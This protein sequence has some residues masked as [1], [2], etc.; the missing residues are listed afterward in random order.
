MVKLNLSKEFKTFFHGSVSSFLIIG[1]TGVANL[2]IRLLLQRNLSETDYGFFYSALAL[3]LFVLGF[4]DLGL[5]QALT[6]LTAKSNELNDKKMIKEQLKNVLQLKIITAVFFIIILLIF[7]PVIINYYLKFPTRYWLFLILIPVVLF[8]SINSCFVGFLNGLKRY[9]TALI[10]VLITALCWLSFIFTAVILKKNLLEVNS[11]GYLISTFIPVFIIYLLIKYKFKINLHIFKKSGKYRKI[12]NFC[13]YLAISTALLTSMYYLDTIML[14]S[15]K[16]LN[17]SSKYNIA[18]P[19]IHILQSFMVFVNV[20]TPIASEMWVKKDHK[21]LKQFANIALVLTILA[22][23]IV[24]IFFY[25]FGPEIVK[26][27]FKTSEYKSLGMT[28]TILSCGMLFFTLNNFFFQM[29]NSG[30]YEKKPVI[31]TVIGILINIVLNF[32]LIKNYD[33][34]GAAI[35]T[36][37]T[38]FIMSIVSYITLNRSIITNEKNINE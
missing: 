13:G 22:L 9:F 29:L 32:I 27:L 7:S 1:L 25:Y 34:N 14:T 2:A 37:M 38:Y 16:G 21:Q 23:P 6:I 36:A 28:V 5:G 24:F 31:I 33:Y 8:Q 26:L 12:I 35:A 18:L 19:L 3:I 20:F 10:I 15:L 30:H 11:I 17:S 4:T